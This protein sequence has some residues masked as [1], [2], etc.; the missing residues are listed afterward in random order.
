[1]SKFTVEKLG[2][3]DPNAL[4]DIYQLADLR[5]TPVRSIR[6][7]V[8]NGVLSRFVF[9]HRFV[10]FTL[11]RFDADIAKFEIKSGAARNGK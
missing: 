1:M 5:N 10:R 8:D 11:A 9:G 4:I 3:V 7:M 6:T 2:A